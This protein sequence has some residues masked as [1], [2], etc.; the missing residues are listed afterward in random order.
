MKAANEKYLDNHLH[1]ISKFLKRF[2]IG[3]N[4]YK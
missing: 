4:R 3:S 1:N 2:T